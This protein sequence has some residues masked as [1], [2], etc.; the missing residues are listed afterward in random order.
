LN[1]IDARDVAAGMIAAMERG[2]P[3][4][5]YLLGHENWTIR[6]LFAWVAEQTG[7]PGPRW[8]VP[9]LVALTAAMVS[10]WIA[11]VFTGEIPAASTTGVRLTRRTMRF[12]PRRSL[13]ELGL[14]PR[15]A[16]E[17]L[18]EA[19]AWYRQVGWLPH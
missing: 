3:G 11:D 18:S 12:D 15:P 8:V 19:L 9:Y 2:Q 13:E 17:S 1:L 10:E 16:K 6:E 5:R 4:R 7:Q 14:V